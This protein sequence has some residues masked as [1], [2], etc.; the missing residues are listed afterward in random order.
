MKEEIKCPHCQSINTIAKGYRKTKDNKKR[1]RLCKD[2]M[3]KFTPILIEFKIGPNRLY[4]NNI[5]RMRHDYKVIFHAVYLYRKIGN[6]TE[7][8]DEIFNFHEIRVTRMTIL[9]WCRKF[10]Q[11]VPL[12]WG[13]QA[14]FNV[15]DVRKLY[16]KKEI[17]DG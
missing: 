16:Y 13:K 14:L 11:I 1:I 9:N 17:N 12:D 4:E 15:D 5:L 7:V 2:C 6:Y 10:D 3:R 8:A